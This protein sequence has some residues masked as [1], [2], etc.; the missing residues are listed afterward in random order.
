M[1]VS[2]KRKGFWWL[3]VFCTGMVLGTILV[4]Y[5]VKTSRMN[6]SV[7]MIYIQQLSEKAFDDVYFFAYLCISRLAAFLLLAALAYMFRSPVIFYIITALFG[8]AFGCTVSMAALAYGSTGIVMAAAL[9]FPQ[10]I[11]YVPVYI[12]LLK[13]VDNNPFD[14]TIKHT[15]ANA[16][17]RSYA[18]LAAIL[19]TLV[20]I[21]CALESYVNPI[22]VEQAA[23]IF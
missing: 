8:A 19:L 14:D 21:G 22:V 5:M 2:G 18:M 16:G 7:L 20:M 12:F 10:Y 23:K 13:M 6:T 17:Y 9:F 3:F 11:V 15:S 1:R 4:N